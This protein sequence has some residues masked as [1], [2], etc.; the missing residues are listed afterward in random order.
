MKALYELLRSGKV[1]EA[2]QR[3]IETNQIE[4]FEWVSGGTPAFDNVSFEESSDL[5]DFIPNNLDR[6]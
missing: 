4:L 3:L 1:I 5:S 6:A 2:Q